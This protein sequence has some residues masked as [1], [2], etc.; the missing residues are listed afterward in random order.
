MVNLKN[1]AAKPKSFSHT[2]PLNELCHRLFQTDMYLL[3]PVLEA[4]WPVYKSELV[5]SCN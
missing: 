2:S 5:I 1:T 3:T 4:R